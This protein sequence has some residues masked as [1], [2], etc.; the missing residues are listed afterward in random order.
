MNSDLLPTSVLDE[1]LSDLLVFEELI[2]K[3]RNP[4]AQVSST[5][6]KEKEKR[7]GYKR[8]NKIPIQRK[9]AAD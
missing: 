2:E 1:Y 3:I 5:L 4:E 6:G 9:A 8:N 7:R